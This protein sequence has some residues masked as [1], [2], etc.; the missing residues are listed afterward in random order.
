MKKYELTEHELAL[1]F[2]MWVNDMHKYDEKTI[3]DKIINITVNE[4]L[5]GFEYYYKQV[6]NM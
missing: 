3:I 1:L 5:D 4:E 6:K 2:A